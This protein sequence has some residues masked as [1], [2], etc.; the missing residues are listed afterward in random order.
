MIYSLEKSDLSG[1]IN[2]DYFTS[3]RAAKKE[4]MKQKEGEWR[5]MRKQRLQ[6]G[7]EC[8]ESIDQIYTW[9]IKEIE[10]NA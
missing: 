9:I 10:V 6:W 5:E 2:I 7:H 8:W 3:S 4:M 1:I